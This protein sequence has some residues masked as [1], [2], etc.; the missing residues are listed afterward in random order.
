MSQNVLC[1]VRG[2]V[3]A[4]VIAIVAMTTHYKLQ[5]QDLHSDW[6]LI[7][8][9]S[10][11]TWGLIL[12]YHVT[13]FSWTLTH[14]HWPD[15]DPDDRSWEARLLRLMQ[16]PQQIAYSRRRFYFSLFYTL[17][18]VY[19]FMITIIYWTVLVP[20]GHGHLPKNPADGKI[21]P[22]TPVA[23]RECFTYVGPAS[24]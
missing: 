21:P 3:L 2:V 6:R 14:L 15:V 23:F 20:N 5:R 17:V 9:F 22:T 7:F 8:Q 19:S 12:V 18:H 4:C 10:S 1:Y 11:I 16:P 24:G 13:V